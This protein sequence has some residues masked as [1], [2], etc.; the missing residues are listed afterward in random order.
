MTTARD[1]VNGAARAIG[2][3]G[4][5]YDLSGEEGQDA[6]DALNMMIEQWRANHL[7]IPYRTRVSLTLVVGDHDYSVGSGGDWDTTR[8]EA[9]DD[10]LIRDSSG[11]DYP[12][13]SMTAK[14]YRNIQS[15]TADA[16]PNRYY[17]E[18]SYPLANL[19]FDSEPSAAETVWANVLVAVATLAN[20]STTIALP[21]QYHEALKYNLAVRLAS[22]NGKEVSRTVAALAVTSRDDLATSAL[23]HRLETLDVDGQLLSHSGGYNINVE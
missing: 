10:M 21:L 23:A 12:V 20:L 8:F 22:E 16:R 9:I 15:K 3:L 14:E 5:G 1:I 4:R 19:Y 2:L 18:P 17:Y 11:Y 13:K 6:L 7:L